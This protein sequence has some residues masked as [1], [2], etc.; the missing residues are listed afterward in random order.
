MKRRRQQDAN[1]TK[2]GEVARVASYYARP[3]SYSSGGVNRSRQEWMAGIAA[4]GFEVLIVNARDGY[5]AELIKHNRMSFTTLPHFGS[6]RST[7]IP[8]QI[9]RVLGGVGLVYLHEG[10]TPS[11]W[12]VAAWCVKNRIPYV[13]LP[14]GVYE[15]GVV[16]TL[17]KLPWRP[18]IERWVLEHA[19]AVHLFFESEKLDIGRLAPRAKSVVART[20]FDIPKRRWEVSG[21]A[22]YLAWLGRYDIEHKGID[23]LL[24]ALALTPASARPKIRMHGPDYNG[25]L[26]ETIQ[27]VDALGLSDFVAVGPELDSDQAGEF[28]LSADAFVHVPRWEAFGRTIAESLS[29][30]VPTILGDGARIAPLLEEERAA[31]VVDSRSPESLAAVFGSRGWIGYGRR[32]RIW[33]ERNLAWRASVDSLVAQLRIEPQR[34]SKKADDE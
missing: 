32:G 26:H 17:R 10:W 7:M 19:A 3:S 25:G 29:L 13:V 12:I 23:T 22:G 20:G 8:C 4:S 21:S 16:A 30:G 1:P 15:P 27:M 34:R 5:I 18:R 31:V 14:H 2:V 24:R 6:G 28:L 9:G 33:A 11:N